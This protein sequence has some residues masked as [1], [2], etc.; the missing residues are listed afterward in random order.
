MADKGTDDTEPGSGEAEGKKGKESTE[1]K[2]GKAGTE[3]TEGSPESKGPV[4]LR[5]SVSAEVRLGTLPQPGKK[6]SL[7]RF[8]L[9]QFTRSRRRN[10]ASVYVT[11]DGSVVDSGSTCGSNV[12]VWERERE[13]KVKARAAVDVVAA[14]K[15][16]AEAEAKVAEEAEEAKE[17]E[18]AAAKEAV[19]AAAEAEKT[20]KEKEEK[21]E[22]PPNAKKKAKAE[23]AAAAAAATAAKK[24]AAEAAKDE[25]KAE[26]AKVA[27]KEKEDRLAAKKKRLA[28]LSFFNKGRLSPDRWAIV[29]VVVDPSRGTMRTYVD[30]H[31]CHEATDLEEAD[32]TLG[33]KLTIF[34][35]GKAAQARGG[36][37]RRVVLRRN[38]AE[39]KDEDL[40]ASSSS[41]SV[42]TS[43]TGEEVTRLTM[44]LCAQSPGFGGMAG[45]IQRVFRGYRG[46]Q[47]FA[48]MRGKEPKL[49]YKVTA[50]S[51]YLRRTHVLSSDYIT[52][53]YKDVEGVVLKVIYVAG[54]RR[55]KIETGGQPGWICEVR[56]D[57]NHD[58]NGHLYVRGE[59]AY[60]CDVWQ[61]E[62]EEEEEEEEKE[63]KEEGGTAFSE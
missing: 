2:E 51:V 34:G 9:P 14:A 31:L 8:T 36:D 21:E 39:N 17:A 55:L 61:E 19:D 7:L 4:D 40:T 62:E 26:A 52:S 43:T 15:A 24:A 32:L 45:R 38:S 28:A 53:V 56:Q 22:K 25:E 5:F 18:E 27:A 35:G 3:N 29:T 60:L 46:R 48:A 20:E 33:H 44:T 58:Q 59:T 42:S 12:V 50:D 16:V 10:Y 13:E 49:L 63:G 41:V 6:A 37:L 30:G 54:A 23:A 47:A 11:D 1:C 57:N